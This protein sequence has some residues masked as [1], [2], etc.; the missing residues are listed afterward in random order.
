MQIPTLEKGTITLHLSKAQTDLLQQPSGNLGGK[1]LTPVL[2][3]YLAVN[4]S[5]GGVIVF[6]ARAL[7]HDELLRDLL[8]TIS[9]CVPSISITVERANDSGA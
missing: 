8:Q 7:S 9:D 6:D 4:L 1:R 5:R 2:R 3:H